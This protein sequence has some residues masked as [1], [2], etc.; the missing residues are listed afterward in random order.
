M[1]KLKVFNKIFAS[2][3]LVIF[4][5]FNLLIDLQLAYNNDKN[6]TVDHIKTCVHKQHLTFEQGALGY[7]V[8]KETEVE[9]GF[10]TKS[11]LC[12]T[13]A[14][15]AEAGSEIQ[16]EPTPYSKP[17]PASQALYLS[18]GNFRI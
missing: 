8:E 15:L 1:S 2:L 16:S 11:E 3:N 14:F 10:K 18:L 17:A 12:F 6:A 13:I 7:S 4:I 9:E 5:S